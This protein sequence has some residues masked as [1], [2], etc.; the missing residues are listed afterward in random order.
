MGSNVILKPKE[1]WEY[2]NENIDDLKEKMHLIAEHTEYGVEIYITEVDELPKVIAFADDVQYDEEMIVSENDCKDTITR[3]YDT[4]LTEKFIELLSEAE[5]LEQLSTEDI[6]AER[7][8]ELDDAVSDFLYVALNGVV[9]TDFDGD[10]EK[11]C[12]DIKE[13][14][15]EYLARDQKLK[16]YRPM[17]LEDEE[18]GEDFYEEYPYEC[19]VYDEK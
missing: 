11:V 8:T 3:F 15:L 1:V 12:R 10:F 7:E 17:I 19:L 16:V 6:I 9:D 4:F 14:F 2:F 18:T 13:H 5:I